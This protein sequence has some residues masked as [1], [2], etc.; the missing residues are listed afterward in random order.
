M[1]NQIVCTSVDVPGDYAG[2][3]CE[4]QILGLVGL[5]PAVVMSGVK[6]ASGGAGERLQSHI[7]ASSR[8]LS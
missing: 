4:P 5:L 1:L 6:G 7:M 8:M 2:S 3:A